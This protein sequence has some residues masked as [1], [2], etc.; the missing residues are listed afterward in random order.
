MG[1]NRHKEDNSFFHFLSE[2]P[3]ARTVNNKFR[4]LTL[5]NIEL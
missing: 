5:I 2:E 4:S 1:Q 3:N